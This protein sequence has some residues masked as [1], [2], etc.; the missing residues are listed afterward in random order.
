M[1][2]GALVP[3]GILAVFEIVQ[4]CRGYVRPQAAAAERLITEQSPK[5]EDANRFTYKVLGMSI[6]MAGI[7]VA[8][9]GAVSD[10]HRFITIAAGVAVLIIGLVVRGKSR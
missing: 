3:A 5:N 2:V 8:I 9:L 7:V 4:K 6:A 1:M 10:E